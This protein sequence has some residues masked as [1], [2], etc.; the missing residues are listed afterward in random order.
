MHDFISIVGQP[1]GS[2]PV[3]AFLR[4]FGLVKTDDTS[5]FENQSAGISLRV[6][7]GAVAA[8]FLHGE[9]KD[10][11][12]Q[13]AGAMLGPINFGC[14]RES[15]RAE[16]GR[17]SDSRDPTGEHA[18]FKHGGWDRYDFGVHSLHFSY[19]LADG[20][21][22]LVTL[23]PDRAASRSV[24]GDGALVPWFIP[25]LVSTLLRREREKNSPLTEPEV[26]EIRDQSLVVMVPA[27]KLGE[28]VEARGYADIDREQCWSEWQVARLQFVK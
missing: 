1:I 7:D 21:L 15:I 12:R 13:F 16:L 2:A 19:A 25:S 28:L 10:G 24:D 9:G 27:S 22:E 3:R 6:E 8:I 20:K 11:F 4:W 18:T 26:L 5:C 17:P 14:T 23:M